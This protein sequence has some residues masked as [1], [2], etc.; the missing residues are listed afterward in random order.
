[1]ESL[2]KNKDFSRVYSRGKSFVTYNLVLYYYPNRL[3]YNRIGY[4]ISKK[5]GNAV[6][7]NKLRRR[8]KEITRLNSSVKKGYD[9]IFIA[10]KPVINL[11][12]SGLERDV[13]KLYKKAGIW[14]KP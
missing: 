5:I 3:D 9:L 6:V 14:D 7:R 4:S 8:L 11:Q 2:K 10:R 13:I 12:Y 1:M